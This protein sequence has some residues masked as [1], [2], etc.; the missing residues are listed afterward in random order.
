MAKIFVSH[1]HEDRDAAHQIAIALAKA[2]LDPWMDS[3]ELRPG[4]ELLKTIATVLAEAQYFAIVLSRMATTKPWVLTGMRMALTAEIEKAHPKVVVLRLDDCEV[5][6]ELRHKVRRTCDTGDT[7]D[8]GA[9]RIVKRLAAAGFLQD[10]D[11]LDYSKQ[12]E[13]AWCHGSILL[14]L[15]RAARRS[16]LFPSLPPPL[17][18][19]LSSLLAYGKPPADHRHRMVCDQIPYTRCDCPRRKCRSGGRCIAAYWSR[20]N[21]GVPVS[22]RPHPLERRKLFHAGRPHASGPVRVVRGRK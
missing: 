4:D 3:P 2:G 19:R 16:G 20:P 1:A 5:P 7:G 9:R 14:V 6:I 13:C 17:P 22:R 8:A 18:E 12:P 21:V 11:D 15:Q 10:A